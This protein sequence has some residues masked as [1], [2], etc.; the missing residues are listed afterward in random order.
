MRWMHH[1][2]LSYMS[3]THEFIHWMNVKILERSDSFHCV[4]PKIYKKKHEAW[5]FKQRFW[6]FEIFQLFCVIAIDV[7]VIIRFPSAV[8]QLDVMLSLPFEMIDSQN[9]ICN[10]K[11]KVGKIHVK[12]SAALRKW[13]RFCVFHKIFEAIKNQ[14]DLVDTVS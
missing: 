4:A 7:C 5:E 1:I 12:I 6:L 2:I 10:R 14:A 11:L 3:M 8:F 13:R 9:W